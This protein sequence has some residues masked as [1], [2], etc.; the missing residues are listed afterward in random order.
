MSPHNAY[1]KQVQTA[2]T[3]ID[4]LLAVY[5]VTVETLDKGID[6]L[7]RQD[8]MNYAPVQLKANQCYLALLDGI[9]LESGGV[10]AQIHDL[11]VFCIGQIAEPDAGAW[12][13][14]RTVTSTLREAFQAIRSEGNELEAT[15]VIPP[16]STST[17]HTLLHA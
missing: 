13:T 12:T 14:A 2:W 1:R 17:S 10:T 9:D 3:R 16:L 7:N 11:C 8:L 4:M 6:L 5:D 15:G